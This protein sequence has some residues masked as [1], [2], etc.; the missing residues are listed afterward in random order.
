MTPMISQATPMPN[1][2]LQNQPGNTPPRLP[3]AHGGIQYNACKNP[4][5][6]QFGMPSEDIALRSL[7]GPYAIISGGKG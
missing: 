2:P 4:K 5:C 3:P 1:P 7:A 6:R